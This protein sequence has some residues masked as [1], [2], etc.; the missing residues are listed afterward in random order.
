MD[1]SASMEKEQKFL[2]KKFFMLYL[3]FLQHKYESVEVTFIRYH[4]EADIC[5]EEE[6]FYSK[7]T[8][9]TYLASAFKLAVK[10]IKENRD[11]SKENIYMSLATDGGLA[12]W[13]DLDISTHLITKEIL[14]VCQFFNIV[15]TPNDYSH[16]VVFK[17]FT[18]VASKN[19]N[20]K[21]GILKYISDPL[22]LLIRLFK[23]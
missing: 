18:I 13:Q 3:L 12:D 23:S 11:I 16:E 6:F 14:P 9:G 7:S 1:V 19:R 17:R 10:D 8:G 22:R 4:E 20:C 5:T 15:Y 2:S 21:V